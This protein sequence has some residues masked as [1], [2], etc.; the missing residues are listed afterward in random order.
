LLNKILKK[1]GGK[2]ATL[3]FSIEPEN[4]WKIRKK[5]EEGL[6]GDKSFYIFKIGDKAVI[7]ERH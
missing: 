5:I 2:K 1:L 6:N 4:Y 3:R 7:A